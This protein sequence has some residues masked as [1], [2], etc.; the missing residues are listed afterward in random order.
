[1]MLSLAVLIVGASPAHAQTPSSPSLREYSASFDLP[2]GEKKTIT[3]RV[4]PAASVVAH[5]DPEIPSH[6]FYNY[7]VTGKVIENSATCPFTAL[8]HQENGEALG[9]RQLL[10]SGVDRSEAIQ[11]C[12]K[13]ILKIASVRALLSGSSA[14]VSLYAPGLELPLAKGS[15]RFIRLYQEPV[16]SGEDPWHCPPDYT[17]PCR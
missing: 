14:S 15:L 1:M 12:S 11:T 7:E 10:A 13:L 6:G 8:L 17:G 16:A 2:T 9:T 5:G 4:D 3:L